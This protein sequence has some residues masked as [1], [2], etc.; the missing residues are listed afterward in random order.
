M[1]EQL[2]FRETTEQT[3]NDFLNNQTK[4]PTNENKK[5]E[6]RFTMTNGSTV[7]FAA[8]L[9]LLNVLTV[10]GTKGSGPYELPLDKAP[11]RYAS[12]ARS[13]SPV[14]PLLSK[15]TPVTVVETQMTSSDIRRGRISQIG[16]R[17]V[18]E[19]VDGPAWITIA[20]PA[21]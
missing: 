8:T 9:C 17:P 21:L 15:G 1:G 19:F 2:N 10:R 7:L 16:S 3:R 18:D 12:W 14:G 6:C 5:R 20:R 11:T 4:K 13:T